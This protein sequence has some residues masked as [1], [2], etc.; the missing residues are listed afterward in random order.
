MW[1]V[2]NGTKTR[3]WVHTDYIS[4]SRTYHLAYAVTVRT[5]PSAKASA[6]FVA[7]AGGTQVSPKELSGGWRKVAISGTVGGCR[8]SRSLRV[9]ADRSGADGSQLTRG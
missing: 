9:S 3:G 2:V 7:K 8:R 4:Q 5:R 6:M 1:A